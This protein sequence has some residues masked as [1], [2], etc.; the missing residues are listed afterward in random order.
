MK[1]SFKAVLSLVLALT[2]VFCTICIAPISS[3]ADDSVYFA[4]AT[5]IHV[6][7]KRETLKKNY[8]ENELYFHAD[9]SGN[10]YDEAAALTRNFLDKAAAQDV[11]FVLIS[12]DLTRSGTDA[13]HKFIANMLESFEKRTGLQVYV[14]PGNHDY[15][16]NTP[17]AFKEFYKNLC[18]ADALTVDTETASY[19]ADLPNGY[20]LI[21]VDSNNPGKDGDGLNER[22]FNWIDEQVVQARADGREI[23]YTEH[24]SVLEHLALGKFVMKDFIVR[25]S[26]KVAERFCSWGIQYT[27]TGH[28]HGNDIAKYVG[29][30]GNV[31]Y[32]VLTTSLSSYPL[33]YRM[34]KY[35]RNGVS[36]KMQRIE[37][38]DFSTLIDGYTPEQLALMK[39]DYTEYSYGYFR[40]SIEKKVLK[41]TSPEFIK[42]KLKTE[43]GALAD[44]IDALMNLV[45]GA[46]DMPLYDKGDGSLSMES[47]AAAKGV[48][49]PKSDYTSLCDLVTALVAQHYYGDE[50]MPGDGSPECEL[51]VKGLN[52][53]LE[54]ILSNAGEESIKALLKI[55]D[56]FF[57]EAGLDCWFRAVGTED[58]YDV[59]EAVL[60]PILEQFTIDKAPADR[61]ADLPAL[62]ET[63][64]TMAKIK[65]V[66]DIILKVILYV[67]K[68]AAS[69]IK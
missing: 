32:D 66:I 55:S 12:G 49:L 59:A 5:D 3:A 37:E 62:G 31:L 24:H 39:S 23:I 43:D 11:D 67:L 54:Y 41:Y 58:S 53:G 42:G 2:V 35:G 25:D 61:D 20:R 34:V 28:E 33:E 16:N 68:V 52:T 13:E 10:L 27:F 40:Y 44:E 69:I 22:L 45:N 1:K 60:Y 65:N 50:N 63:V 26:D 15:H 56:E 36:L 14:V 38:C 6:G 57:P 8:P 51:F 48:T 47:L 30:N 17:E 29:K 4:L 18:Y 7:E 9:G 21:A 19:T 46:L 64:D